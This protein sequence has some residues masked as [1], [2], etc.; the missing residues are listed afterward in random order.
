MGKKRKAVRRTDLVVETI[1]VRTVEFQ[2]SNSTI[3]KY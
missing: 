3:L 1:Q 2:I